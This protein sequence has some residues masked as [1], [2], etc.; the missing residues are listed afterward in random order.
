MKIPPQALSEEAL[1]GIIDDYI[2]REGTDYGQQEASLE[3]KRLQVKRQLDL[4]LV[5]IH[6]D[7]D[8][9]SCTLISEQ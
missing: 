3:E 4:G 6:Y 5:S 8:L 9:E 7:A 1:E 2:L